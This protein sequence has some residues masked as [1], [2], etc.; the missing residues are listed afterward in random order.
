M[1]ISPKSVMAAKRVTGPSAQ[2]TMLTHL[3]QTRCEYRDKDGERC[4][5]MIPHTVRIRPGGFTSKRC[6]DHLN[7]S[8]HI[9]TE[10]DFAVE[11]FL[12]KLWKG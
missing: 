9:V 5:V 4:P 1:G 3:F 10:C 8:R 6:L 11:A 7:V 12:E 2:T